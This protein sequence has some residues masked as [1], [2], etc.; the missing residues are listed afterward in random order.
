MHI[1]N[2]LKIDCLSR[3]WIKK[4]VDEY[5]FLWTRH[6]YGED[7]GKRVEPYNYEWCEVSCL[8]EGWQVTFIPDFLKELK[9]LLIKENLFDNYWVIYTKEKYGTF[10][11][12]GSVETDK[13]DALIEKYNEILK[14]YCTWC[15]DK[16]VK[17][18]STWGEVV[19]EDC[20]KE[21]FHYNKEECKDVQ[22]EHEFILIS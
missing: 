7:F 13:I 22:F 17:Y 2:K 6:I 21:F 14:H 18:R 10:R 4:L 16:N 9:E 15:G 19:C 8:P 3:E 11:W 12:K 1:N 5:P 20:A